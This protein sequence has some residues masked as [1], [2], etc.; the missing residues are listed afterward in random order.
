MQRARGRPKAGDQPGQLEQRALALLMKATGAT[1]RQVAAAFD[2]APR[3]V[4]LWSRHA[5]SNARLA[6]I[7]DVLPRV[8]QCAKED[9]ARELAFA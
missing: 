2:V 9:Q 3:T 8:I 7:A 6:R 4:Q 5:R 1:N